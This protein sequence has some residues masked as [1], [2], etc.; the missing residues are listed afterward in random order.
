[1]VD[2]RRKNIQVRTERRAYPR[3]DFTCT[4]KIIGI[5]DPVTITD[6]SLGGFFF[7][8]KLA[9]RLKMGQIAN[10]SLELPTESEP[11]RVKARMVNQ[12]ERGVGCAFVDLTPAQRKAIHNC[13]ETFKDTLPVL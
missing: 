11:T 3:L 9:A 6:I 4:A 7:E 2:I 10:V 12:N 1:M 8:I 5:K 13:F